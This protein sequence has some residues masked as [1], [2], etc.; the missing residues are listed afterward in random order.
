MAAPCPPGDFFPALGFGAAAGIP[1]KPARDI[2][3]VD[4]AGVLSSR[5]KQ[6]ILAYSSALAKRTKTQVVVLTVPTLDG[7]SIEDYGLSVL[8]EW[9]I[10]D[11]KENNGVLLLVAP[12]TERAA[13]KWAMVWK[14]SFL[15]ASQ[16]ESR[17]STCCLP[18]VRV[19]MTKES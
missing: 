2:Y 7:E 10:G 9:G 14:A 11:K 5:T 19:I 3:V 15:T 1:P 16:G 12:R 13:L 17:I 6:I 8:R 18:S 4:E